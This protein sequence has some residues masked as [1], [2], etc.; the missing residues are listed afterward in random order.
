MWGTGV[1][2]IIM[3]VSVT[4][5]LK[6][7]ALAI[8]GSA[9]MHM[10]WSVF[11]SWHARG[12][13]KI[14]AIFPLNC[15]FLNILYSCQTIILGVWYIDT[16]QNT[17]IIIFVKH[18]LYQLISDNINSDIPKH[19]H[20]LSIYTVTLPLVIHWFFTGH[21]LVV[22]T[23]VSPGLSVF[24]CSACNVAEY[25]VLGF[26]LRRVYWERRAGRRSCLGLEPS[27]VRNSR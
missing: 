19:K 5:V 23:A 1:Q 11:M 25:S 12:F 13:K 14:A 24:S 7:G 27:T 9:N 8:G 4:S 21:S 22:N 10:F 18:I 3:E 15:I 2:E 20:P 26:R 16:F 6:W 17:W